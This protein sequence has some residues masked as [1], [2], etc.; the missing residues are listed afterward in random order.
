[1]EYA[2]PA[3]SLLLFNMYAPDGRLFEILDDNENVLMLVTI[4]AF[5]SRRVANAA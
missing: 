2:G 1:M 5:T 4:D 3:G